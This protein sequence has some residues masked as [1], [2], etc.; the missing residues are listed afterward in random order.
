[1]VHTEPLYILVA[2]QNH[3]TNKGVASKL[4]GHR[5]Q[6]GT[7]AAAGVSVTIMVSQ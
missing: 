4:F 3:A 6:P 1:M 2:D 5:W 7:C